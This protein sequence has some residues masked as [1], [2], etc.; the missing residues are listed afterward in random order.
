MLYRPLLA[1]VYSI[2]CTP[3]QPSLSIRLIKTCATMCIEAAQ[4]MASVVIETLEPE[5]PVGLMPWWQRI[6][7]LHIAATIFLASMFTPLLYTQ[8]V[9]QSWAGVLAALRAHE[10]ICPHVAECVCTLE[11]L[12]ERI[13]AARREESASAM[14][15]FQSMGMDGSFLFGPDDWLG[16][17]MF[18]VGPM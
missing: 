8:A 12:A 18:G 17:Q 3:P 16:D 6:F 5:A 4:R 13:L 15:V 10:H 14:D 1:Q 2:K 7:H 11:T 9:E